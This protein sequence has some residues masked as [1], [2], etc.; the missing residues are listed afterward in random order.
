MEQ[1]QTLFPFFCKLIENY[2]VN[3]KLLPLKEPPAYAY[4]TGLREVVFG[5]ADYSAL[6]QEGFSHV[7]PK[8]VCHVADELL[9]RYVIFLH[10]G[11]D[12]ESVMLIGPYRTGEYDPK[13]I[14]TCAQKWA[15]PA[16]AIPTLERAYQNIP[17]VANEGDLL[18]IIHS[19]VESFWE[20]FAVARVD[21]FPNMVPRDSQTIVETP[22]ENLAAMRQLEERYDLENQLLEAV[23]HGQTHKAQLHLQKL[24]RIALHRRHQEAA[25]DLRN[26][27]ILLNTLL[28]KAAEQGAVH[29]YHIDQLSSEFAQRIALVTSRAASEKLIQEMIQRYCRLVKKHATKGYSPLVRRAT[30]YID[31]NLS[32]D[33]SLSTIA[34]LLSINPRYL[35]TQFHQYTGQTLTDYVSQQRVEHAK[36][37][38]RTTTLQVQTV[39]EYCGI[40]DV[41]YFI[42]VFKRYTDQ[43]PTAYRKSFNT[44]N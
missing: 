39:S 42:K 15:L 41:N 20:D 43:T 33:L 19:Y 16:T 35:S 13:L 27:G 31:S 21:L 40:S 44:S 11:G 1:S 32:S 24:G 10:P 8:T 14:Y 3:T 36:F 30:A 18:A 5:K 6:I 17:L 12:E 4:D 28:R 2:H 23:S 9:C 7:L 38:L 29:P 22:Q 26:Y 37:L 34:Q 25:E